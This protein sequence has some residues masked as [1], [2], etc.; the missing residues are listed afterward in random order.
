M[1]IL[2]NITFILSNLYNNLSHLKNIT[3]INLIISPIYKKK[4]TLK[5]YLE[6]NIKYPNCLIFYKRF[7]TENKIKS[8]LLRQ[9][10]LIET[11]RNSSRNIYKTNSNYDN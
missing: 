6:E 3:S 2:F 8:L 9:M 10:K 7:F 11:N 1:V 4:N 5:K